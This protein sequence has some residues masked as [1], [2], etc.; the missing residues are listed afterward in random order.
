MICGEMGS[1]LCCAS[2]RVGNWL[3][4][5]GE[6]DA[7]AEK[8]EAVKGTRNDPVSMW[9]HKR[10]GLGQGPRRVFGW[11]VMVYHSSEKWC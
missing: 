6:K 2:S 8:A 7:G 11:G 9:G 5:E 10:A 4:Q 1:G 3:V